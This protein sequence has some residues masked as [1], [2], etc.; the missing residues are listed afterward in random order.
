[1]WDVKKGQLC[2][3]CFTRMSSWQV[4]NSLRV[5]PNH[6]SWKKNPNFAPL[7][8]YCNFFKDKD[9][10]FIERLGRFQNGHELCDAAEQGLN[11]D[12]EK[13][14]FNR[15]LFRR[16]RPSSEKGLKNVL[17]QMGV[18]FNQKYEKSLVF[19]SWIKK[20]HWW[21]FHSRQIGSKVDFFTPQ[22]LMEELSSRC[23]FC[24]L[25]YLV[26]LHRISRKIKIVWQKCMKNDIKER[27]FPLSTYINRRP[28]AAT[29]FGS[30]KKRNRWWCE[31]QI[32]STLYNGRSVKRQLIGE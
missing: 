13:V 7:L 19:D 12:V 16:Q 15:I 6:P 8:C 31:Q 10:W 14:P 25:L 22:V 20:F 2:T 3:K 4:E 9:V 29:L 32:W 21:A 5:S 26:E 17:N 24:S 27:T 1:M 28:C 23:E 30:T 18:I 11:G